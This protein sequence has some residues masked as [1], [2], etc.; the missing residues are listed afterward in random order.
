MD[1]TRRGAGQL[2]VADRPHQLAEMV[3]SRPAS[4]QIRW[5]GA[6]DDPP[7]RPVAPAELGGGVEELAADAGHYRLR[8]R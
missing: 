6:V 2:L 8:T 7:E 4:A 1:G 5:A 3:G